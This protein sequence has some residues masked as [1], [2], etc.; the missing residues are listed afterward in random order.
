MSL[1]LLAIAGPDKGR[2]YTLHAG[3][4]LMLGRSAN[5]Y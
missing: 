2:A 1:Q 5:A 4:D 3:P